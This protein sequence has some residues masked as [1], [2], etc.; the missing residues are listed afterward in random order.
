[1]DD[2]FYA[3]N[4][5]HSHK[6]EYKKRRYVFWNKKEAYKIL[7][8]K[9]FC[10]ILEQTDIVVKQTEWRYR[11]NK[12]IFV[13]FLGK[14]LWNN[15]TNIIREDYPEYFIYFKQVEKQHRHFNCN[16][17]AARKSVSDKYC[18]WLFAILN[19]LDMQEKAI[20]GEEFH[21]RELGYVSEFLFKVWILKEN[22]RYEAIP[23][24]NIEDKYAVTGVM[25]YRE[26]MHF[27]FRKLLGLKV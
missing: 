1:L 23:V 13:K 14:D 17:F 22:L 25:N 24:V 19:K 20:K 11:T 2:I 21:N 12:K 7:S 6:Q 8:E 18:E 16:M 26:F 3:Y 5:K 15:L 27:F 9:D 4:N 10:E